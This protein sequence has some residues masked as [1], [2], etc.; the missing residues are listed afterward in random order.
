MGSASGTGPHPVYRFAERKAG[1]KAWTLLRDFDTSDSF[2]WTTLEEGNYQIAV[3]VLD[4]ADSATATAAASF[5]FSSRVVGGVPVVSPTQNPLVFLYSAPPC[6]AGQIYINFQ[7]AAGGRTQTTPPQTCNGSTSLN[8]YLAGLRS[9]TN[10]IA[11]QRL[12]NG[13]IISGPQIAFHTGSPSLIFPS[14]AVASPVSADTDTD[15]SLILNAFGP[16]KGSS[17]PLATDLGGHLLWYYRFPA[18]AWSSGTYLSRPVPGGTL[19]LIVGTAKDGSQ[20]FQEIDLAGNVVRQ[21]GVW[22]LNHQ[23]VARGLT[24]SVSWISHEGLRLP[25]Q[26]TLTFGSVERLMTN[27]QGTGTVDILGDLIL[28]LDPNLQVAWTWNTFDFLNV[29]QAAIL[30][31]T[32]STDQFCGGPLHK[33]AVANDWT[34]CS[35]LTYLPDGNL[36]VAV[37]NQDSV[38]KISYQR[39][40]GDGHVVWTLGKQGDFSLVAAPQ[41]AWPWFSHP[42]DVEFDGTNYELLDNGNTRVAPP[43]V[44]LGYG[45]SR[46]QVLSIDESTLTAT[47]LLNVDLGSYSS[48]FGSAQRLTNGNYQFLSGHTGLAPTV[49]GQQIEVLPHGTSNFSATWAHGV[50]R[51]FRMKTLYAE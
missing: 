16:L 43:P 4:P 26:H 37:R 39:G 2:Q 25:N 45:D 28:D 40:A 29:R 48:S 12:V 30:G 13:G 15:Q 27:V 20:I 35:S 44:G 7:R 34:H 47:L 6:G 17:G 21:T 1:R 9:H 5:Q 36:L 51:T 11:Q 46:G 38:L 3:E 41:D 14:F 10:Y 32:C 22:A 49:S 23:L 8:F 50:Y 42:H 33:A 31:E 24:D 19:T 18:D